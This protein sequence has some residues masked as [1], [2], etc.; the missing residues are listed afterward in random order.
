MILIRICWVFHSIFHVKRWWF[1]NRMLINCI[2]N[3]FEFLFK[4]F[5]KRR[6]LLIKWWWFFLDSLAAALIFLGVDGFP[7]V[8]GHIIWTFKSLTC[9]A[10]WITFSNVLIN[11]FCFMTGVSIISYT[12]LGISL[13]LIKLFCWFKRWLWDFFRT[14]LIN[15]F[16]IILK[17]L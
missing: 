14:F 1:D 8:L 13:I 15:L 9:L 17:L 7:I 16:H 3:F 5:W 11:I 6:D 2:I 10:C 4:Y 12:W